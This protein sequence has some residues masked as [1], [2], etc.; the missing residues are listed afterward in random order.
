MQK[1]LGPAFIRAQEQQVPTWDQHSFPLWHFGTALLSPDSAPLWLCVRPRCLSC[2]N[3][4]FRCHWCKY[5]N[6]CTHDPSSCSFQE[7]RVNA[8]EV[9]AANTHARTHVCKQV[10]SHDFHL[11][12]LLS[13]SF[14]PA[15]CSVFQRCV[16]LGACLQKDSRLSSSISELSFLSQSSPSLL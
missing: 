14:P 3:S 5:R 16:S 10:C 1:G 6:L 11:F 12:L 15:S 8:S 2:V 4:A 7:G 9:G 13:V